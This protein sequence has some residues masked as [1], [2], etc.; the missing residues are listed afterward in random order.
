MVR[1]R[2]HPISA[3]EVDLK[4]AAEDE[5]DHEVHYWMARAARAKSSSSE[6][7]T[8][9]ETDMMVIKPKPLGAPMRTKV[10]HGSDRSYGEL[11]GRYVG[12]RRGLG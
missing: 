1:A 11:R 12:G 7:D 5:I 2:G 6:T 9:S 4:S 3:T 10:R 8:D